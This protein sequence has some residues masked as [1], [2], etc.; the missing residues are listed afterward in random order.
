[1]QHTNDSAS[2]RSSEIWWSGRWDWQHKGVVPMVESI[3]RQGFTCL[4]GER[5]T[6]KGGFRNRATDPRRLGQTKPAALCSFIVACTVGLESMPRKVCLMVHVTMSLNPIDGIPFS[7][8]HASLKQQRYSLT[9]GAPSL[10]LL[11]PISA[12][13]TGHSATGS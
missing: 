8:G 10:R 13:C 12:L 11:R 2:P 7:H 5:W 1:M 4:R 3:R 6:E 9:T